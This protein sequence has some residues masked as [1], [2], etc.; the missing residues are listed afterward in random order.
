MTYLPH[1]PHP[2][3]LYYLH[4]VHLP[5]STLHH[6][7]LVYFPF[8]LYR[9]YAGYCTPCLPRLPDLMP[10]HSRRCYAYLQTFLPSPPASCLC[11][12]QHHYLACRCLVCLGSYAR[13]SV[14]PALVTLPF[15]A[16]HP[17]THGRCCGAGKA[18]AQ[19]SR[20]EARQPSYHLPPPSCSA[21]PATM[22]SAFLPRTLATL[23]PRSCM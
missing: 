16:C 12:H 3:V 4:S 13:S 11:L 7:C 21:M 20:T 6:L 14:V 10:T 18:A 5:A 17:H 2:Y 23:L 15:A 22:V 8:C 1:T 19:A 9:C